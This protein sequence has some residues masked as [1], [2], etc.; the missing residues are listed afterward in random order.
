MRKNKTGV[1]S[2][3]RLNSR[4]CR[5]TMKKLQCRFAREELGN[6]VSSLIAV[7]LCSLPHHQ[8]TQL[9]HTG[10][11][12]LTFSGPNQKRTMATAK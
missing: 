4:D 6:L 5:G 9:P 3:V 8:T 7:R 11:L 12:F 2:K 10:W 1:M